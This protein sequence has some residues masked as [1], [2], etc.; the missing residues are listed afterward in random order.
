M[1]W[2]SKA[3]LAAKQVQIH[4]HAAP[5]LLV[6]VLSAVLF[7]VMCTYGLFKNSAFSV[8]VCNASAQSGGIANLALYMEM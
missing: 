7:M 2:C 5:L 1:G 8:N 6:P 3:W 4:P